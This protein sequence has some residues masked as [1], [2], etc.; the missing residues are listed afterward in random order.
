VPECISV[1]AHGLGGGLMTA[2]VKKPALVLMRVAF[3][4]DYAS[5]A[6]DWLGRSVP[7][8]GYIALVGLLRVII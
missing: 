6:I 7:L 8:C 5:S 2:D 3:G 4:G 1:L